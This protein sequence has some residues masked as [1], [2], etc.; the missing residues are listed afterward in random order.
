MCKIA[1]VLSKIFAMQLSRLQVITCEIF[2]P[3]SFDMADADFDVDDMLEESYRKEVSNDGS[4]I[5]LKG[6]VPT[7]QEPTAGNFCHFSVPYYFALNPLIPPSG[8]RRRRGVL[9]V[10]AHDADLLNLV[11]DFFCFL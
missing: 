2:S 4:S 11:E 6:S 8:L 10:A 3:L 7:S 1:F 5:S 9:C